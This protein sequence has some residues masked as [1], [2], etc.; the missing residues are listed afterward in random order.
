MRRVIVK[1]RCPKCGFVQATRSIKRVRCMRCGHVYKVYVFDPRG[2]IKKCRIVEIVS[3]ST[4]ELH[5]YVYQE[6]ILPK[7]TKRSEKW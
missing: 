2:N 5:K 6:L 3:G 1:V 4:S 7:R